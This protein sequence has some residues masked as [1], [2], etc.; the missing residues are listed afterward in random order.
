MS[1]IP[2]CNNAKDYPSCS[3]KW[4]NL[5]YGKQENFLQQLVNFLDLTPKKQFQES[6]QKLEEDLKNFN[7]NFLQDENEA[8]R[9]LL[10]YDIA[11]KFLKIAEASVTEER[12]KSSKLDAAFWINA[13]NRDCLR[14]LKREPRK[15]KRRVSLI[16]LLVDH[17]RRGVAAKITL[18]LLEAGSGQ[19]F[20]SP[21]KNSFLVIDDEFYQSIID[22]LISIPQEHRLQDKDIRWSIERYGE[23]FLDRLYGNSVG[24]AFAV[25][26]WKL[27]TNTSDFELEDVAVT[28]KV[29]TET[30]LDKREHPK[31]ILP[32]DG[33]VN[34]SDLPD[35]SASMNFSPIGELW[36][37]IT[38]QCCDLARLGIL[39]VLLIADTQDDAPDEL[40]HVLIEKVATLLPPEKK[41]VV[42]TLRKY[43]KPMLAVW[44]YYRCRWEE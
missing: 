15:L 39:R 19:I 3:M 6:F 22:A 21:E 11:E 37:K 38:G 10:H 34:L 24:G 4:E 32:W 42:F 18:E 1:F 14:N 40:I 33:V 7:T 29:N 43:Q 5:V 41:N 25:G 2:Q 44:Q 12:D 9:Y 16:A 36:E 23:G 27:F 13:W 35:E 20:Q 30:N 8:S 17:D 31:L 28:A 26:L